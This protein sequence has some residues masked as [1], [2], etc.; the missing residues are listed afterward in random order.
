MTSDKRSRG[1]WPC[2]VVLLMAVA[3]SYLVDALEG[4]TWVRSALLGSFMGLAVA[5]APT[6]RRRR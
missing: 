1:W 6:T 2:V 4:S 3:A 5:L